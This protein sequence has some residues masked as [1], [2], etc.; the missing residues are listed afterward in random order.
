MRWTEQ[1]FPLR[2]LSPQSETKV[3]QEREKGGV[4]IEMTR[5]AL[6]EEIRLISRGGHV[7]SSDQP[8]KR[9]IQ[10]PRVERGEGAAGSLSPGQRGLLDQLRPVRALQESSVRGV[11]VPSIDS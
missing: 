6:A 9:L 3:A 1:E 2:S 4:S 5:V 10:Q 11:G 8:G 7:V